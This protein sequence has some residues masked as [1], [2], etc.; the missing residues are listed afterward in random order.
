MQNKLV[1]YDSELKMLHS[2]LEETVKNEVK[3]QKLTTLLEESKELIQFL[4]QRLLDLRVLQEVVGKE[5][6][7]FKQRRLG[8]LDGNI[9]ESLQYIFPKKSLYAKTSCNFD[10]KNTKLHL[11]L[12]DARGYT[13]PTYLT[14]GK[15]A[16]QLISYNE[17]KSCSGDAFSIDSR[18]PAADRMRRRR[19]ILRRIRFRQFRRWRYPDSYVCGNGSGDIH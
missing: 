4:K 16:Q 2:K 19:L 14:E 9:T 12:V 15:F 17:E 8:Y 13:R 5:E 10:R 11:S 1:W 6:V 7:A 18:E 3:R